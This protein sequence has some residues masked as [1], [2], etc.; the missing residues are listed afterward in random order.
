MQT[1]DLIPQYEQ[2][3]A[4]EH[5]N[6]ILF[7]AHDLTTYPNFKGIAI[8]SDSRQILAACFPETEEILWE[9]FDKSLLNVP[10]VN[11][12]APEGQIVRVFWSESEQKWFFSSKNVL[13]AKPCKWAGIS[14]GEVWDG[15]WGKASFGD[16]MEKNRCYVFLVSSKSNSLVC[17][18]QEDLI[19]TAVFEQ[20]GKSIKLVESKLKMPHPKVRLP[21][22][23]EDAELEHSVKRLDSTLCSGVLVVIPG[24]GDFRNIKCVKIV[25]EA[26]LY[27]KKLR[28]SDPREDIRYFKLH[29]GVLNGDFTTQDLRMYR[30][31]FSRSQEFFEKI[32]KNFP[33]M[34]A[35]F[36]D[37][38]KVRSQLGPFDRKLN[39]PNYEHIV[40]QAVQR[41]Y[42]DYYSIEGNVKWWMKDIFNNGGDLG[43]KND[44]I[45][46]FRGFKLC[47]EAVGD[48]LLGP[49]L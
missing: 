14:I 33:L 10:H 7:S 9:K 45:N 34:Y 38:F 29:I 25:N 27:L 18:A 32:D 5:G 8:E 23:I 1:Q 37:D 41:H 19:L 2:R 3:I 28:G 36:V 40:L 46:S 35:Q 22:L 16:F 4:A 20:T 43:R 12:F 42:D 44:R 21:D 31:A 11:S 17:Q 47:V 15:L 30:D 13:D 6:V 49:E 39:V 26:F 48:L 24:D